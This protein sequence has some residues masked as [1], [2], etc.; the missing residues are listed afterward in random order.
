MKINQTCPNNWLAKESEILDEMAKA[1]YKLLK[2]IDWN[3]ECFVKGI[4]EGLNKFLSNYFLYKV[5]QEKF[6]NEKYF[7]SH[8]FSKAAKEKLQKKD[9]SDLVFEHMVPKEEYIQ[10]PCKKAAKM[11]I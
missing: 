8:Y 10:K 3:D 6:I 4:K 9:I 2:S 7:C 5:G 11:V 1:Y